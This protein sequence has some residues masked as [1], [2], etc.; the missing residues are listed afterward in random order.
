MIFLPSSWATSHT[1]FAKGLVGNSYTA[2]GL[3][4]LLAGA[5]ALVS[6]IRNLYEAGP[7]NITFW[8]EIKFHLIWA[9]PTSHLS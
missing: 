1:C 5:Q 4:S 6:V 7:T 9:G 3:R 2:P 8:N